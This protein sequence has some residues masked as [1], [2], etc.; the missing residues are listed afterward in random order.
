[1][2]S[3]VFLLIFLNTLIPGVLCGFALAFF[4]ENGKISLT[5]L[6]NYG[7]MKIVVCFPIFSREKAFSFGDL[8]HGYSAGFLVYGQKDQMIS[9]NNVNG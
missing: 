1:M 6:V 5:V 8:Y 3:T 9:K 4:R 2:L 7:A